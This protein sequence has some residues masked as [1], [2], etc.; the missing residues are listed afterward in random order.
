[1]I[2]LILMYFHKKFSRM[3]YLDVTRCAVCFQLWLNALMFWK[4]LQA[5]HEEILRSPSDFTLI[6]KK[7][8]VSV[9][10]VER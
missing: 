4:V 6:E 10:L 9:Y 1:M 3:T 7:A 5:Y 8:K 2:L